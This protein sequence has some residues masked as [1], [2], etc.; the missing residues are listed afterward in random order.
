MHKR[1]SW[2]KERCSHVTKYSTDAT[3]VQ[4]HMRVQV[5]QCRMVCLH[6][7]K[8]SFTLNCT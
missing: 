6:Y 5:Q 4:G 2:E 8:S 3:H 1:S 7:Q